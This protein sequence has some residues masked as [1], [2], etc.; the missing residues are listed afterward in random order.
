[1]IKN[2]VELEENSTSQSLLPRSIIR[3][4]FMFITL[5]LTLASQ[6]KEA[7]MEPHIFIM[8]MAIFGSLHR[9]QMANYT[10]PLMK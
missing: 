4:F 3:V 8:A 5:T 7:A 1:L 10:H 9:S 2:E 6:G